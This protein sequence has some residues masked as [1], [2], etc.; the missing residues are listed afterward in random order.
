[1]CR[2]AL[3]ASLVAAGVCLVAAP[4]CLRPRGEPEREGALEGNPWEKLRREEAR[5]QRL[6]ERSRAVN[7]RLE[8]KVRVAEA[9]RAS[10]LSLPDAAAAFRDIDARYPVGWDLSDPEA[11]ARDAIEWVRSIS[12]DKSR[13]DLGSLLEEELGEWLR[14]GGRL[15]PPR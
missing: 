10:R 12:K 9:L 5:R 13:P 3:L 11:C 1:M 7:E 2:A 8:A 15:P 14:Q 4:S 6:E